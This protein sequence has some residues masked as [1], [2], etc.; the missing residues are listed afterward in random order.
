LN[1]ESLTPAVKSF[2]CNIAMLGIVTGI[3]L[4]GAALET[5]GLLGDGSYNPEWAGENGT[6]LII[7]IVL[8]LISFLIA[9]RILFGTFCLLPP[10]WLQDLGPGNNLKLR[11]FVLGVIVY[12][13]L[14]VIFLIAIVGAF[15][16]GQGIQ[17]GSFFR[18][19]CM[20]VW[21]FGAFI[22]FSYYSVLRTTFRK[23]G[24]TVSGSRQKNT[25]F[26]IAI[27]GLAALS[28]CYVVDY[29]F[30]HNHSLPSWAGPLIIVFI[31]ALTVLFRNYSNRFGSG[32]FLSPGILAGHVETDVRA[33]IRHCSELCRHCSECIKVF[34]AF[35]CLMLL[36]WYA[37]GNG[38]LPLELKGFNGFLFWMGW[39]TIDAAIFCAAYAFFVRRTNPENARNP[40]S[41]EG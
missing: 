23:E 41:P 1:E 2:I 15:I 40:A 35:N 12:Y 5:T 33:K 21:S 14:G 22:L 24:M 13:I 4:T 25:K 19:M 18:L 37:I 29:Y 32:V 30:R 20:G 8:A 39:I 9:M 7:G 27:I 16:S 10:D 17:Q 34:I 11:M 3:I 6:V 26:F 38:I 31:C 28:G 36:S